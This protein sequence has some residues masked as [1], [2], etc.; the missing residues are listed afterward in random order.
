M[1][2]KKKWE[3]TFTVL[4]ILLS[5]ALLIAACGSSGGSDSAEEEGQTR[6]NAPIVAP[7][8][9]GTPLPEAPAYTKASG[10]HPLIILELGDDGN[11]K[12]GFISGTT[13]KQPDGWRTS[14]VDN[15][16]LV[17]CVDAET[18]ELVETCEYTLED[19]SGTVDLNRYAKQVSFRLVEAQTGREIA[20]D[21]LTG[22]PR[23]CQETEEFIEDTTG[24][25][26]YGDVY[27]EMEDWLRPYVEIP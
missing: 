4:S 14:Y 27:E 1:C 9:Q 13:Y 21:T 12:Y 20:A 22:L 19:G 10:I 18:D 25:S 6:A 3:M 15:L 17:V 8:C 24:S 7:I 16:E 23:E 26:M 11:Y 2:Y 5:M